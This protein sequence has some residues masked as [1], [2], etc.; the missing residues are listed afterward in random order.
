MFNDIS[1]CFYSSTQLYLHCMLLSIF[2]R[3]GA[4]HSVVR[5]ASPWTWY[6]LLVKVGFGLGVGHFF[7]YAFVHFFKSPIEDSFCFDL[8]IPP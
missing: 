1:T 3:E 5:E 7:I 2:G 8:D 6:Q 4:F